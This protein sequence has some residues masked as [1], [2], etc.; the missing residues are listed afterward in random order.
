MPARQTRFGALIAG[1][2]LAAASSVQA[3][4]LSPPQL[5]YASYLGGQGNEL[6]SYVAVGPDGSVYT[7]TYEFVSTAASAD[8][9][10]IKLAAGTRTPVYSVPVG[11]NGLDVPTSIAVASD[12][13]PRAGTR[14]A[15]PD[16]RP[17]TMS[18]RCA[19]TAP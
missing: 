4:V 15:S 14:S 19:R 9:R 2:M 11:G 18:S 13:S 6:V 1:V 17:A 12:G 8:L 3:Q 10:V 7:L 5:R 16:W